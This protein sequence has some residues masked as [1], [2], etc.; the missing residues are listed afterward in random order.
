MARAMSPPV[1]LETARLLL[2]PPREED[3]DAWA[4]FM[5]DPVAARFIGGR[6]D[7][8][9]AWR[10][11]ATMAGAWALRGFAMFSVIEKA[12]GAWVGRVG[13]WRPEGWPGA[14]VGWGIARTHW[15]KGY[16]REAAVASIDWA[17][18]RLGWTDVIH[19]ID[20]ANANSVRVAQKL[21]SAKIGHEPKLAGFDVPVDIWGQSRDAWRARRR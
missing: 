16:A 9:R 5:G 10:S 19:C 6:M 1:A 17:F 11:L 2:R 18:D 4:A 3:L 15:G 7:R 12:S 8:P 14:E 20:P 13:P 21:G